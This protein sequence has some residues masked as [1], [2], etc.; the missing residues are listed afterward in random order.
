MSILEIISGA[1][2]IFCGII[3]ILLVVAQEP[4]GGME[5][6]TG[7]NPFVNIQSRSADAGAAKMTKY[8][9]IAFFVLAVA[10]SAINILA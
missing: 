4:K 9:G 2:L 1:L 10:V 8:A 6:I 5:A 7:S 3:I